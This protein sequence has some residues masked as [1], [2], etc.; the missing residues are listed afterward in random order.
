MNG[1]LTKLTAWFDDHANPIVVKELRQSVRNRVFIGL[2]LL[3]LGV[4]VVI[5]LFACDSY[6]E[7]ARAGRETFGAFVVCLS[8]AGGI[9]MPMMAFHALGNERQD[10]TYELLNVS[11]LGPGR[12]VRG[13]F[14]A[15]LLQLGLI[16]SAF[17]PFMAF[18]YFLRGVAIP[19]MLMAMT[20]VLSISIFLILLAITVSTLATTKKGAAATRIIFFLFLIYLSF[21]ILSMGAFGAMG[22]WRV[23]S[24]FVPDSS[25]LMDLAIAITIVLGSYGV[26]FYCLAVSRLTFATDNRSTAIRLALM[27]QT[28][29][30]LGLG[31]LGVSTPTGDASWWRQLGSFLVF[32]WC[33]VGL[34][35]TT[36]PS[37]MS[38]RVARTVPRTPLLCFL[39]TPFWPGRSRGWACLFLGLT[40]TLAAT[41]YGQ[42]MARSHSGY[43]PSSRTASH[44]AAMRGYG[45]HGGYG[46]SYAPETSYL[47]FVH[48][49]RFLTLL[50]LLNLLY[51]TV[52]R[53]KRKPYNERL[54]I[55]FPIVI[56][57]LGPTLVEMIMGAR[58]LYSS[59]YLH[60]LN[61]LADNR[62]LSLEGSN[63]LWLVGILG[64]I[65]LL[66]HVP[67]VVRAF[68]E[69]QDIRRRNA[70]E[71][72]LQTA[73]EGAGP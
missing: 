62:M 27:A 5:S 43:G 21:M 44:Y 51:S 57:T 8:I 34:F 31:F 53:R 45:A 26:V 29:L 64:V 7:S 15:M 49:A 24:F 13:K 52:L 36:E 40:I 6:R 37:G 23:L 16:V 47:P 1:K 14:G 65:T 59:P 18:T 63:V 60:A 28:L 72:L 71:A 17:V 4:C 58:R 42:S 32:Q 25:E 48:A 20:A 50:G 33:L 56:V 55:L 73:P 54:S 2:F 46:G 68:G 12:I 19:D 69:M 67:L 35:M 30:F 22:L 61:P 66:L 11:G 10:N 41:T 9:I 70:A 3:L 38:R 39:A